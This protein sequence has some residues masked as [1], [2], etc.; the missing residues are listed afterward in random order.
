MTS[1][2]ITGV[3]G[4]DGAYL[5]SLLATKG[6]DVFG[7]VQAGTQPSADVAPMIKGVELIVGDLRDEESLIRA[8]H[9]SDP[10]EVYNLAGLS[11]VAQSWQDPERL[12]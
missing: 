3:A 4:Q 6:Y 11:S 2:L 1:A 12:R 5:S 10:D 7:M 8:V 9:R